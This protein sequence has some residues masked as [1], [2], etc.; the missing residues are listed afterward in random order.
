MVKRT[1]NHNQNHKI[2]K[3]THL[4]HKISNIAVGKVLKT[5][6][7]CRINALQ[8]KCFGKLYKDLKGIKK[9]REKLRGLLMLIKLDQKKPFFYGNYVPAS[10]FRLNFQIFGRVASKVV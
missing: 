2:T 3:R 5:Y 7:K 6:V 10:V 9:W 1:Q 4:N 8:Q